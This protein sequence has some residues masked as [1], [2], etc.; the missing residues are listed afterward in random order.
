MQE[1]TDEELI[2]QAR[3]NPEAFVELYHRFLPRVFAYIACRV[4]SRQ[5]TED[6]VA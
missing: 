2:Q 3:N 6:L 4:G 5:D 1:V